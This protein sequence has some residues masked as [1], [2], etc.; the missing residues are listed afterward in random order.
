MEYMHEW[1]PATTALFQIG[2]PA[3][4]AL[5]DVLAAETSPVVRQ[6]AL[7]TLMDISREDPV[8]G[9]K[10]MRDSA[11]TRRGKAAQARLLDAARKSVNLCRPSVRPQCE[12]ALP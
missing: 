2:K 12:A 1:Y 3:L 11:A 10:L 5:L 4:P 9:V 6:K 7:E 8:S